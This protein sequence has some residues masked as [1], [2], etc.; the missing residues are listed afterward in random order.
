MGRDEIEA[1]LAEGKPAEAVCEFC[2]A[3][4]VVGEDELRALLGGAPD[5]G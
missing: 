5:D 2:S 3:A 4:Y 1:M